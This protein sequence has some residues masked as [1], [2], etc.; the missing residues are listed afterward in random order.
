ME[1]CPKLPMIHFD[2]K[3]SPDNGDFAHRL[4]QL[5]YDRY[6]EDPNG[7]AKEISELETLRANACIRPT[8]DFAGVS[9][10]KRY[11]SQLQFL[12]NR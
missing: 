12:K 10:V 5:I 2:L 6:R 3:F 7:F 8:Q 11:Y 1:A 9:N 4:K